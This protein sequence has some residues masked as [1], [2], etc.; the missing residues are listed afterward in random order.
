MFLRITVTQL[1][2]WPIILYIVSYLFYPL[3]CDIVSLKSLKITQAF[4]LLFD[5]VENQIV[6]WDFKIHSSVWIIEGS[7]N[8]DLDIKVLRYLV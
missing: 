3:Y 6:F 5:F 2:E 4:H 1:Y 8:R 7:D